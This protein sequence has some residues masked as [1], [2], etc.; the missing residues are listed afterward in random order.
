MKSVIYNY[1]KEELKN[2][3]I[4][5]NSVSEIFKKISLSNSGSAQKKLLEII[6]EYGLNN[7]LAELRQRQIKIKKEFVKHLSERNS[8]S[9]DEILKEGSDVSR[10]RTREYIISNNLLPY[11][12]CECGISDSYNGR[13]L[14]LQLDHINGVGNDNRLENLRF[15]CPNCHSQTETWG[16]RNVKYPNKKLE[17]QKKIEENNRIWEERLSVIEKYDKTKWGWISQAVK[18]TGL[19]KRQ[20]ENTCKHFDIEFRTKNIAG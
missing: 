1:T 4:N 17:K 9:K 12:C 5:S 6:T 18:E 15:L 3:I 8:F 10:K 14:T 16:G 11:V 13:P 2:L 7:E 20:I 19:T